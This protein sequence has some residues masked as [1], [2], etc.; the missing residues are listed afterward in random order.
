MSQTALRPI[1]MDLV[2]EGFGHED[3]FVK[4]FRKGLVRYADKAAIRTYVL[5]AAKNHGQKP[6]PSDY[7]ERL[8]AA[9]AL[10]AL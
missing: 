5:A 9:V 7:D 4:L 3:I 6:K 8:I 10:E 2:A 1:V